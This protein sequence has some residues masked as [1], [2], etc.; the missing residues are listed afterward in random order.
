MRPECALRLDSQ[1]WRAEEE[2]PTDYLWVLGG[3]IKVL[4]PIPIQ[5]AV[6]AAW[7][8]TEESVAPGTAD[9]RARDSLLGS[10]GPDS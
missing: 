1:K 5:K 8:G 10:T 3:A 2:G 4:F 7:A 9:S 6:T